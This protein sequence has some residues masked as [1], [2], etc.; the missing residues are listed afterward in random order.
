M[1][2][3]TIIGVVLILLCVGLIFFFGI[4]QRNRGSLRPIQAFTRLQRALGLAVEEGKRLHISIGKSGINQPQGAAGLVGLSTLERV[5]QLSIVSDNPPIATSG[6]PQLAILSQDTLKSAY[7]SN[8]ALEQ[9]D[10]D[11]G[12]LTGIT[13]F[14]YLAGT[15]PI[16]HEEN[17]SA[18]ILVGNFGPE[19]ALLSEAAERENAFT[20]AAT[21]SLP[22]QAVLYAAAQEPLIGE[23]LYAVPA[24]LQSNPFHLAS[25]RAEDVLRWVIGGLIVTG[26]VLKILGVSIL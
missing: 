3:K 11:R 21:D 13:P 12:R 26:C 5:A 19:I 9:H 1:E 18:H 6:D 10:P 25:L 8:N 22:A 14:S 23:E 4:L 20:L 15:L 16:A 2:L 17:I 7:R 24:Y